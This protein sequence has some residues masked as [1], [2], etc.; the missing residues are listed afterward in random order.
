[1]RKMKKKNI[2]LYEQYEKTA[3]K[4]S[5]KKISKKMLALICSLSGFLVL[6]GVYMLFYMQ[7]KNVKN[8]YDELYRKIYSDDAAE[9]SLNAT[10]LEYENQVLTLISEKYVSGMKTVEKSN[11]EISR[12]KPDLISKILSCRGEDTWVRNISYDQGIVF[13]SGEAKDVRNASGFVSELEKKNIFDHI[14]YTGYTRQGNVF[15]FSATGYF[16][17]AD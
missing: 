10:Q 14:G 5:K 16:N 9:Q 15:A 11:N 2:N 6:A 7:Y 17:E 4:A 12:L 13:I 1:M 3:G 8:E